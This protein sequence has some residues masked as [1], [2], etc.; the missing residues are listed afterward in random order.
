M[1]K[2]RNKILSDKWLI[3]AKSIGDWGVMNESNK[4]QTAILYDTEDDA[5][6]AFAS[7]EQVWKDSFSKFPFD[8]PKLSLRTRRAKFS[9]DAAGKG[10]HY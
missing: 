9:V 7:I 8:A 2:R 4:N 6:E 5:K 3:E 1:K 10:W